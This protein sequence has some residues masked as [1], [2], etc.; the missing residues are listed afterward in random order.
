MSCKRTLMAT[1][2]YKH[3]LLSYVTARRSIFML[4]YFI[5]KVHTKYTLKINVQ[6]NNKV[7]FEILHQLNELDTQ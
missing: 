1:C 7:H 5:R 3:E 2:I 6:A 4:I